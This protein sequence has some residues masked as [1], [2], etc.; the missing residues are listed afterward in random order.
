MVNFHISVIE[1][2][3]QHCSDWAIQNLVQSPGARAYAQPLSGTEKTR[4]FRALYRYQ[5]CCNLF[6]FRDGETEHPGFSADYI[7][8]QLEVLFEPWEVEELVCITLFFER[9]SEALAAVIRREFAGT[10]DSSDPGD[11]SDGEYLRQRDTPF[12][13]FDDFG[14]YCCVGLARLD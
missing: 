14:E 6:G 1:P 2:L 5:I 7:L 3:V 11:S 9:K 8:Q 4:I 10:D 12:G 13:M